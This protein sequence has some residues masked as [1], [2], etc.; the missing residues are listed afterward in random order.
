MIT[1]GMTTQ[2]PRAA[3]AMQ[4]IDSLAPQC[5][6][7][8]VHCN[9]LNPAIK[10]H[11]AKFGNV[12][13]TETAENLGDQMKVL[14][15]EQTLSG[16]FFTCDDDIL[17]PADYTV[18]MTLHM[19]TFDDKALLCIHGHCNGSRGKEHS[20]STH[21]CTAIP[22]FIPMTVPGTGTVCFTVGRPAFR[23]EQITVPN[24]LDNWIGH[25]ALQQGVP[26]Y[27]APRPN[28]W[29][30]KL[31]NGGIKIGIN[32]EKA[33]K[34]QELSR[35]DMPLRDAIV[36]KGERDGV[37]KHPPPKHKKG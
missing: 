36:E 19:K 12:T 4:A 28:Q 9:G 17:Y 6:R 3:S 21:F 14:G 24:M 32:N 37:L 10:E 16:Y 33:L 31:H 7:M 25:F 1:V 20:Y 18:K 26:I 30:R 23:L 34:Q 5:D 11:C 35:L 27:S 8:F 29:L 13:V 15:L 22:H 2:V